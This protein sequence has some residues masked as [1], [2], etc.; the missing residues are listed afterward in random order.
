MPAT[1]KDMR[2]AKSLVMKEMKMK[3][4]RYTQQ[5]GKIRMSSNINAGED[6]GE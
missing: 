4:S 5:I 3:F 6:M 1:S 2:D